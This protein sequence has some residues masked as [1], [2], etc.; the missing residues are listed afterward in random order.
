[1]IEITTQGA[2][3]RLDPC[4]IPAGDIGDGTG[5]DLSMISV[6]LTDQ[7]SGRR[8]AIGDCGDVH[9]YIISIINKHVKQYINYYMPTLDSLK[10]SLDVA[11]LLFIQEDP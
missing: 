9:A 5:F 3:E 7:N 4:R 10:Y 6:R 2:T 1:M 8:I 11:N